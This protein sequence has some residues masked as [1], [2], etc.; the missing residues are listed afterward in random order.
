MVSTSKASNYIESGRRYAIS[1]SDSS[2]E[3]LIVTDFKMRS[4]DKMYIVSPKDNKRFKI[5]GGGAN[6]VHGGISLHEMIIPVISYKNKRN[7][8]K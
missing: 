3:G 1:K 4:D 7:T 2:S 5:Q 6:F 8:Q